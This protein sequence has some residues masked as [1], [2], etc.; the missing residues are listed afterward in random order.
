[1]TLE[2]VFTH[3]KLA[4]GLLRPSAKELPPLP[5][6]NNVKESLSQNLPRA[7][8]RRQI[9]WLSL[10]KGHAPVFWMRRIL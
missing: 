9:T 4:S 7:L 1:M 8:A 2:V 10:Y 5:M 6:E 3:K